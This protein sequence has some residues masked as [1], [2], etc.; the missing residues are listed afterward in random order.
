MPSSTLDAYWVPEPTVVLMGCQPN[1]LPPP[2]L[3][4]EPRCPVCRGAA[5]RPRYYCGQCDATDARTASRALAARVG[6]KSRDQAAQQEREARDDLR[7]Q[8]RHGKLTESHRRR[9]WNGYRDG[10]RKPRPEEMIG[11]RTKIGREWLREKGWEPDWS[12]VL[13]DHGRVV[14][15]LGPEAD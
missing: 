7:A 13:D 11:S 12:L 15:R 3:A 8:T 6:L 4:R 5:M 14:G 9:I 1:L 2:T 10:I